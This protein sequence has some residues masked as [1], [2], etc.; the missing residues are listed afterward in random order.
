MSWDSFLSLW[1]F[2]QGI[3]GLMQGPD[4]HWTGSE[5][6]MRFV[7]YLICVMG[8]TVLLLLHGIHP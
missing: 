3:A 6:R 1:I 7:F 2:V 8:G 4:Q 5:M